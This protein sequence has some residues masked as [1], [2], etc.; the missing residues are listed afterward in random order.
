[1]IQQIDLNQDGQISYEEF[2][3]MM[4]DVINNKNK[5][6]SMQIKRLLLSDSNTELDKM[7]ILGNAKQYATMYGSRPKKNILESKKDILNFNKE[8]KAK[9]E[10]KK[11]DDNVMIYK[12][13]Q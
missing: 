1:M 4:M 13:N 2:H 9:I 11:N 7:D 8:E 6:L 10:E 5:R 12:N 3:K